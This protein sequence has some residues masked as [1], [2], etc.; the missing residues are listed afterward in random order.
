MTKQGL[1]LMEPAADIGKWHFA[2]G[3][4]GGNGYQNPKMSQITQILESVFQPKNFGV[5]IRGL[6]TPL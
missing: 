2:L 4:M 3:V 5:M 6:F 1:D